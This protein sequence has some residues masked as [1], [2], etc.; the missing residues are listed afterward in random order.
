MIRYS[1]P[2]SG[3]GSGIGPRGPKGD[4]GDQGPQGVQGDPG[5][6]GIQGEKGDKGDTGNQGIQGVTGPAGA[7]G[8]QGE[9]GL[10]GDAGLQ[11][12]QGE[13][14]DKGDKG[15][16]GDQGPQGIQGIQGEQGEQGIQGET[17]A[18]GAT[19]AKGDQGNGISILGSYVDY[20]ALSSA[21][22]S[23]SAGDAYIVDGGE[24]YVWSSTSNDWINVGVI[25]GPQ[26]DTGPQGIQ[27]IQGEQ[28]IQG[29]QGEQGI[30]GIQGAKGDTG[31]QGPQGLKGD[32]GDTGATGA[33][34]P[35]GP[36]G[37][38]GATGATGPVAGSA[39]QII[40]KNGSNAATG[41]SSLTYDGTDLSLSSGKLAVNTQSGDEGGEIFLNKAVT[42]TT[43]NGGVTIDIYQNKLR[44]FEQGGSARGAYIDITTTGAGVATDLVNRNLDSLSDV[45]ITGTPT[46]K[47]LIV[48]DT[49]TSQWKNQD[50]IISTG[51]AY[52]AGF[53]ASKTSTGTLGEICI[54]GTNG[55]LYICTATNTWQKVSLNSANFT[56]AG[57]FA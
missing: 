15:D 54:D 33:T 16:T 36:T 19:G 43:I 13:K 55:T 27:G 18:T 11:G 57:G 52:K 26:G 35:Q 5:P 24:L 22:P 2:S 32:K 51:L 34:G 14:G 6:Q 30:Q 31:D 53:P 10:Q 29:V 28:G 9:Q 42:N 48:Y 47:Q 49:A 45:T 8:I 46:N 4:T 44:F 41:S 23:G 56:N 50:A 1:N 3:Q 21:H 12:V 20:V 38:T 7:Q 25:Q 39:N 40:Y 37:A 17:G